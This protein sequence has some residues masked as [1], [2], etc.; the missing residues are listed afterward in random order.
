MSKNPVIQKAREEGYKAGFEV[1]LKHGKE[2]A[3]YFFASKFDEL[4]KVPGI[5]PKIMEK[6]VRHFGAE[7]FKEVD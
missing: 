2:S 4:D 1:G 3:C 6:V 5:G 7:Y